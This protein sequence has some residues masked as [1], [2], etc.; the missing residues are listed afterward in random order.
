MRFGL[1]LLLWCDTLEDSILPVLE[2]I[3]KI[4]YDAV[5]VPIF[6]YDVAKYALWGK[7]LND[8][9]LARTGVT[10]RLPGNN[11]ISPDAAERRAGVDGNKAALD[12]AAAAGCEVL[13]GPLPFG[14]GLF[15]RRGADRRRMAV[16]RR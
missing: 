13:A 7:R 12:C 15:L 2:D 5:E 3:K 11:P 1:N 16:G 6:E 9:G 8:L 14:L 4:G 10:I